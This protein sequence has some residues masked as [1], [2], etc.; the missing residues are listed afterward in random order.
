[1]SI[2]SELP[3]FL[4]LSSIAWCFYYLQLL[5]TCSP[6]TIEYLCCNGGIFLQVH[7]R[8][9]ELPPLH[10]WKAAVDSGDDEDCGNRSTVTASDRSRGPGGSGR[11]CG[12]AI[13]FLTKGCRVCGSD[14]FPTTPPGREG[15]SSSASAGSEAVQA[16]REAA[17]NPSGSALS[18]SDEVT[19][20]GELTLQQRKHISSYR[21]DLARIEPDRMIARLLVEQEVAARELRR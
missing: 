21:L 1:M 17:K 9:E 19:V 4:P 12:T 20:S 8:L 13:E 18:S 3:V 7:A 2:T 6:L 11:L 16:T 15:Y 5:P 10:T 14:P